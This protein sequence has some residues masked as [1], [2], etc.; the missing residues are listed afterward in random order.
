M[1]ANEME[2][3]SFLRSIN[4]NETIENAAAKIRGSLG[5][6]ENWTRSCK[7]VEECFRKL[8]QAADYMGILVFLNG[9]VGTNTHRPLDHQEFRGFVLADEYAPLIFING[10]D[11]KTAQLFT[12]VHEL[13]H[14]ALGE[15][16]LFN[17]R[18][19][20]IGQNETERRCNKIAAE[21][22]V[23]HVIFESA[24]KKYS[25]ETPLT[26]V[27][28]ELAKFF[29]VSRLVIARLALDRQ[30]ITRKR[31]F[32]YYEKSKTDWEF[33]KEKKKAE[34]RNN[35][36]YYN[37]TGSRLSRRFS[38]AIPY[39][40]PYQLRYAAVTETSYKH[41]K[42]MAQALAGHTSA[43]MTDNYDRSQLRK[44]EKLARKRK[45]PFVKK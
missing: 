7:D 6:S 29:R 19:L 11:T 41:G 32:V 33:L 20:D 24:W 14:L 28:S 3:I 43:T 27:V 4:Q 25:S 16:G 8:R 5:L 10:N 35:G 23:P 30:L 45:N 40:F 21:V 2:S 17:F 36:D 37:T 22:L 9:I 26:Q 18:N 42:D 12:L 13:V 1:V 34:G 39:F 31:F 15:S 38:E 44:R